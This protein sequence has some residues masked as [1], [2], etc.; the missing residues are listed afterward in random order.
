MKK[1]S[2]LLCVLLALLS[3]NALAL[4]CDRHV[5]TEGYHKSRVLHLCGEP[6][7]IEHKTDYV[8]TRLGISIRNYGLSKQDT[9]RLQADGSTLEQDLRQ[10]T[11]IHFEVWT[12][13]FGPRRLVHY[14]QFKDDILQDIKV[15]GYGYR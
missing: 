12:Y 10:L 2:C 15:G 9:N 3:G 13:N 5:V 8:D 11:P 1:I 7:Y 4:R 14:L 6:E